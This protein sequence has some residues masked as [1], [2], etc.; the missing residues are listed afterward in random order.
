MSRSSGT[1]CYVGQSFGPSYVSFDKC[2]G[3][4]GSFTCPTASPGCDLAT[5][6]G[7]HSHSDCK[8]SSFEQAPIVSTQEPVAQFDCGCASAG[9]CSCTASLRTLPTPPELACIHSADVCS[10]GAV[11][12]CNAAEVCIVAQDCGGQ[13]PPPPICAPKPPPPPPPP[14]GCKEVGDACGPTRRCCPGACKDVQCARVN[15]MYS[16]CQELF[17]TTGSPTPMPVITAWR[18]GAASCQAAHE[19]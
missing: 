12:C 8:C 11:P 19:H 3:S 2:V 9:G 16:V 15:A 6:A 18:R 14:P 10:P 7:A 1:D 4:S 17:P 13:A 5:C